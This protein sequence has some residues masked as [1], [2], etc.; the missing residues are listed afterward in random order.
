MSDFF[1][2][3]QDKTIKLRLQVSAAG[4]MMVLVQNTAVLELAPARVRLLALIPNNPIQTYPLQPDIHPTLY[5]GPNLVLRKITIIM[6]G[7]AHKFITL[8]ISVL[9]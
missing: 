3:G 6:N 2:S 8:I 1:R 9:Y 4:A 5:G 7:T